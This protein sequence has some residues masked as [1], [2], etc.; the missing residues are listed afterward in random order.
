MSLESKTDRW[1]ENQA[2]LELEE[3][4]GLKVE[5]IHKEYSHIDWAVMKSSYDHSNSK[6]DM[7]LLA[8]AEFK[9]Q[10]KG[11]AYASQHGFVIGLEKWLHLKHMARNTG[12]PFWIIYGIRTT[13]E[14]ANYLGLFWAETPHKEIFKGGRVDRKLASDLDFLV[15]LPW[16]YFTPL[17]SVQD[18]EQIK[19]RLLSY[20][21]EYKRHQALQMSSVREID[22]LD[23][24]DLRRM[25][26]L[27]RK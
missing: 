1:R 25:P 24:S 22:H 21:D 15:K 6:W 23:E 16:H 10:N 20:P 14:R 5:K 3:Y 11:I 19:D 2:R 13:E 18:Y 9:G 27:Q 12:L 7:R 26:K 4:T 17:N 8:W